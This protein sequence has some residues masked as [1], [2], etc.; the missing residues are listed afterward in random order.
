MGQKIF[1]FFLGLFFLT[2]PAARATVLNPAAS[3][4]QIIPQIVEFAAPANAKLYGYLY[5]PA[6]PGPFP[7][8]L[9]NHGSDHYPKGSLQDLGKFYTEH[10]FVFFLPFRRGHGLSADAGPWI[11]DQTK[12]LK[13]QGLPRKVVAAQV[14]ALHET[15]NLDVVAALDWLKSQNFVDNSKIVVS[16]ISYG[17]IQT[18]LTAEANQRE[19]LGVKAFVA[20]APGAMS[21]NPILGERLKRAV[22][23][24]K[25]PI[26][27]IQAM[28]D[29]S[30]DPS[31]NLGPLLAAKGAPNQMKDYP[32][33]GTTPAEGHGRF[34][35]TQGGIEIWS[36]DV[37]TF[38][39]ACQ[40]I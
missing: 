1:L 36:A 4:S 8:V 20:F 14:I 19:K 38:L 40:V 33:F 37:L 13:A 16:G 21:W 10:G 32:A 9:Y 6:G 25:A 23:I 3:P 12:A 29:F 31:L 15:A 39:K 7:A 35:V 5:K 26:F 24:A 2:N 17:G 11:G 34:A 28:N 18:L 30:L 27:L 22:N